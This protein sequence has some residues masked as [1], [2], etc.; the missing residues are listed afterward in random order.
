LYNGLPLALGRRMI[1]IALL[2]ATLTLTPAVAHGQEPEPREGTLIESVEVSGLDRALLSTALQQDIDALTGQA[3]VRMSVAAL[4]SRIEAEHPDRLAA[5]RYVARP[6]GRTRVVFL[7]AAISD[8]EALGTNINSRYIVERVRVVGVSE[9]RLSDKLRTDLHALV[10][11]R[12]DDGQVTELVR[13]LQ[14]ELPDYDIRHSV[15]RGKESGR[16][17]IT[18]RA[19]LSETRRWIPLPKA[20]TSKIVYH[21]DQGWSTV[22]NPAYS[23]GSNYFAFGLIGWNNDDLVEEQSGFRLHFQNREA[24]TRR[25]G[26]GLSLAW[27]DQD[28]EPVTLDALAM[29]P[30]SPRPYDNRVTVEP[31]VTVAIVPR[32]T[33]S[34]GFSAS[35]LDSFDGIAPSERINAGMATVA[36]D[37]TWT[38]DA[39]T[40]Q[41]DATY[42]WRSAT[43]SLDSDATYTRHFASVRYEARYGRNTFIASGTL[44]RINGQAPLF[45]RFTIGDSSTLRGWDKYI[46]APTGADRVFHQSVEYRYR[47]FAYFFDWG[48]VWSAGDEM[49]MRLA[50]GVGFHSEHGFL[51]FA[52][53]LNAENLSGTFI[54]GARF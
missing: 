14:S 37:R 40:Q 5:V 16:I 28:W 39:G 17:R 24:G 31:W 2:L 46:L 53:P 34:A 23:G 45:E 32:L 30:G 29:T 42:Q 50:T 38:R 13:R 43:R 21:E 20:P 27:L 1:R 22:L 19:H 15:D 25:L 47:K 6:D 8:D 36:Y 11:H 7:V 54:I 10:G 51:T 12:M 48:S 49:K 9:D 41:V 44:G 4:A 33:L 18:F 26:V 3:L 52:V 35:E